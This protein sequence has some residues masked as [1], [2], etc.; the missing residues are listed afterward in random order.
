MGTNQDII[1]VLMP[2]GTTHSDHTDVK[3]LDQFA[4]SI[5]GLPPLA[6]ES[7][8]LHNVISHFCVE[9]IDKYL[10]GNNEDWDPQSSFALFNESI[11]ELNVTYVATW[12][13][14]RLSNG[15]PMDDATAGNRTMDEDLGSTSMAVHAGR[16][17]I[18]IFFFTFLV[19]Q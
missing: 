14:A 12:A 7:T 2:N 11:T 4:R 5:Q 19:L 1:R 8:L 9:F 17:S 13:A 18:T 6:V 10:G 16:W 3:H 15:N